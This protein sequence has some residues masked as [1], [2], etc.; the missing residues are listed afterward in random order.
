AGDECNHAPPDRDLIVTDPA[1]QP[2]VDIV[3][4][5][6]VQATLRV[7]RRFR[8]PAGLDAKERGR[9]RK[10]EW[11]P[12]VMDLTVRA[13]EPFLRASIELMNHA[14]DHRVRALFPLGF[15]TQHS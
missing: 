1:E 3:Q 9:A 14:S 10:T 15:E 13:G 7:T 12:V 6:P 8:I 11:M 4:N 2:V 5:G